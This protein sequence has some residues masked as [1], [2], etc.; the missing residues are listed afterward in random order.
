MIQADK[1]ENERYSAYGNYIYTSRTAGSAV[2]F[3]L[4]NISPT[5]ACIIADI[6]I[7]IGE[8]IFL[9]ISGRADYSLK[10]QVIWQKENEYG[11]EFLLETSADFEHISVIVNGFAL[12][13]HD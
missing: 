5:G 8:D 10:A 4:R 1:R 12:G 6:P 2:E 11:V 3:E 13:S 9:H 7:A